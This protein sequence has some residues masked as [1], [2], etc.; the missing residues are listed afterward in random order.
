MGKWSDRARA[1]IADVVEANPGADDVALLAAIDA[2]YPFGPR[3][4]FPYKAWLAER[5]AFRARRAAAAQGPIARPCGACGA[6]IGRP[7]RE[8]AGDL[9]LALSIFHAARETPTSGPLFKES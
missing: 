6:K 8:I 1:V 2:A 7:C 9:G 4:H 3:E 5:T